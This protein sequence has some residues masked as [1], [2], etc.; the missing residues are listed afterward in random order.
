MHMRLVDIQRLL[1]PTLHHTLFFFFWNSAKCDP[2]GSE[3][4]IFKLVWPYTCVAVVAYIGEVKGDVLNAGGRS[5]TILSHAS[6]GIGVTGRTQHTYE[7]THSST[8]NSSIILLYY[9][10]YVATVFSI[11]KKVGTIMS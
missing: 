10:I 5:L 3:K 8:E 4:H 9:I 6:G 1:L 7:D 2:A 11:S